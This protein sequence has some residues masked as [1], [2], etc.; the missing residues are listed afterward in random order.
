MPHYAMSGGTLIALAADEIVMGDNAVL[1]PA[2]PQLGQ[3][4]AVSLVKTAQEKPK[5]KLDDE[6]LILADP[7]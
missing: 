7:G 2:D 3:Y 6:T 5:D 4:P 1:G